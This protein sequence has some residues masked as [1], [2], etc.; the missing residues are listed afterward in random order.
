MDKAATMFS[1]KYL[2][3][4]YTSLLFSKSCKLI[5]STIIKKKLPKT[6]FS[7]SPA[8]KAFTWF[9]SLLVNVK[10]TQPVNIL[11]SLV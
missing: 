10:Q 3:G 6:K 1:Q 2:G 4:A 5:Q 9:P 8:V 11:L 7:S